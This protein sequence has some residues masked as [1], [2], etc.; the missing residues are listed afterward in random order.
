VHQYNDDCQ[1]TC[2][3]NDTKKNI[4]N[5]GGRSESKGNTGTGASIIFFTKENDIDLANGSSYR[6]EFV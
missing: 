1:E 6:C 5:L 3:S 4:S 2:K